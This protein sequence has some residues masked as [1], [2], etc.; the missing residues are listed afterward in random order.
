MATKAQGSLAGRRVGGALL[1]AISRHRMPEAACVPSRW[2][3]LDS[4]WSQ[5][6]VVQQRSG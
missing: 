2:S 4:S 3:R 1:K 5:E 6:T